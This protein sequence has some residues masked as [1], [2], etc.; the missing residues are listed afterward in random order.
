MY[1]HPAR[2][3]IDPVLETMSAVKDEY[4]CSYDSINDA[5]FFFS[6]ILTAVIMVWHF[7]S[8]F[9]TLAVLDMDRPL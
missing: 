6:R 8:D 1:I 4:C 7:G 3:G 9:E 5:I 2:L